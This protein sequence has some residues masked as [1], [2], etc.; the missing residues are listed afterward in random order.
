MDLNDPRLVAAQYADE[1]ALAIR[2]RAW[3][4]LADG[5]SS[6]DATLQAVVEARPHRVLE[7]GAG[8]GEL[9]SAIAAATSAD[10]TAFDLS[11]RMAALARDRGVRALA[12][13]LQALPFAAATFDVVVANAMLYHL[14]DLRR[15]IA[16]AARVLRPGGWLVATTF[17]AGHTAEIW[18]LVGGPGVDLSF[19]AENGEV[20]LRERFAHVDVRRGTATL[21]FPNAAELRA[22]VAATITRSRFADRVPDFDGSFVTHADFAVFVA[23]DPLG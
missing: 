15:G 9:S 17:G 7:A 23:S 13:D 22:Y 21:T 8:W 4:G 2:R 11:H 10:V 5:A 20:I 16:E 12:G 3:H 6:E 14:P 1:R 19:S 18:E